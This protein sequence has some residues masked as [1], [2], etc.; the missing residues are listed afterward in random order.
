RCG[1]RRRP[2][3]TETDVA[4]VGR[5]F[6]FRSWVDRDRP[7]RVPYRLAGTELADARDRVRRRLQ[8]PEAVATTSAAH[9]VGPGDDGRTIK[10]AVVEHKQVGLI[11]KRWSPLAP[12]GEPD[13]RR[14]ERLNSSK[15]RQRASCAVVAGGQRIK[16]GGCNRVRGRC[17]IGL[18]PGAICPGSGRRW[19]DW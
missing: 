2:Y 3:G 19:L 18:E 10:D 7:R 17:F 12:P 5:E 4:T 8:R 6:W 1:Q 16:P 15:D 13:V 9:T 14:G 11:A